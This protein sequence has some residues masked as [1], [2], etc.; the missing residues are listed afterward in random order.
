MNKPHAVTII[1][2]K[3]LAIYCSFLTLV[4]EFGNRLIYDETDYNP[5][6]MESEYQRLYSLLTTE[7]KGV[8]DTIVSS[9]DNGTGGIYFVYGYGG[10]GKTF[11]WQKLAVGIRRRGDIVLNVHQAVLH[12]C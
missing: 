12:L 3:Y 7:Q 6:E 2:Q 10:T 1:Y 9:V 8:Y 11:L 4:N 5:A